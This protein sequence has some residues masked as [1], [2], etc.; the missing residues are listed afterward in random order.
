MNEYMTTAELAERW[1]TT[2]ETLA[3]KRSKG[4]G[5]DYVKVGRKVLYKSEVILEYEQEFNL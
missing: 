2:V 3:N 4:Q 5:P 1:R